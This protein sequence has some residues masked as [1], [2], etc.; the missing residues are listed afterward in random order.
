M[1]IDPHS[2]VGLAGARQA[3][4]SGLVSRDTPIISLACAHPAKFQDAVTRATGACVSPGMRRGS[5]CVVG[6]PAEAP[7]AA[8]REE[9]TEADLK[10]VSKDFMKNKS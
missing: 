2:A 9:I 3:R 1:V 6:T 5:G 4:A 10:A 8:G 7:E